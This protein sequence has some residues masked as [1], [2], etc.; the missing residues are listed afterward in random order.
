MVVLRESRTSAALPV[1]DLEWFGAEK[2]SAEDRGPSSHPLG[3]KELRDLWLG[4]EK[5]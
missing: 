4:K 1:C 5:S 2:T 3:P